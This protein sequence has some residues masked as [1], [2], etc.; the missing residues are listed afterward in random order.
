MFCLRKIIFMIKIFNTKTNLCMEVNQTFEVRTSLW[1][2]LLSLLLQHLCQY[3][4]LEPKQLAC[5]QPFQL[6]LPWLSLQ[7]LKPKARKNKQIL[8]FHS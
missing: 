2:E 7:R 8:L 3:I 5:Q 6:S 4:Q 1:K